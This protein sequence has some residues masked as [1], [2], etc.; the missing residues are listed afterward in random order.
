MQMIYRVLA[1]LVMVVHFIF[2]VYA[3]FGGLLVLKWKWT[4]L[5]HIPVALWGVLV[6]MFGWI[7]PLTPLENEFRQAAGL[8]GY[9]GG[10][11]DHYLLPVVYPPNLTRPIQL[12]LGAA[13]L[14]FNIAVYSLVIFRS[15]NS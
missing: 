3:I 5:L 9:S 14:L 13:L 15:K 2:I 12:M 4:I 10:F 8:A 7:C 6:E 1:D 11:I